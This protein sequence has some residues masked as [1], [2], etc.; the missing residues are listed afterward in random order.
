MPASRFAGEIFSAYAI[1]YS[2]PI[3]HVIEINEGNDDNERTAS[4]RMSRSIGDAAHRYEIAYSIVNADVLVDLRP[5]RGE[6]IEWRNRNRP[7]LVAERSEQQN[8]ISVPQAIDI[9]S[10]GIF[11]RR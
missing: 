10:V 4:G 1:D 3:D 8:I 7:A 5:H 2:T 9:S 11:W 6:L